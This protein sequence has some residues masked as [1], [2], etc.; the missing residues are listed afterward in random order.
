MIFT[1]STSSIA[2]SLQPGFLGA[3]I[4]VNTALTPILVIVGVIF[5]FGNTG[6]IYFSKSFNSAQDLTVN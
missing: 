3:M 2:A 6:D 4:M 5:D 1:L